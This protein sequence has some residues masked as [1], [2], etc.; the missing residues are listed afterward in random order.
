[1]GAGSFLVDFCYGKN[2]GIFGYSDFSY[3]LFLLRINNSRI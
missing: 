2:I 1:V 3:N